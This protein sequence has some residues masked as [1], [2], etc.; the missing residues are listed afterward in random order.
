MRKATTKTHVIIPTALLESVDKLVGRR[1]RSR[2]LTEAAEKELRRRRLA[3]S[4]RKLAGS[5]VG[6]DTPPEWDT[7]EGAAA[8]VHASRRADD[9]KLSKLLNRE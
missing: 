9:A 1:G 3:V 7:P 5:L 2:F 8:W 6:K 4:A